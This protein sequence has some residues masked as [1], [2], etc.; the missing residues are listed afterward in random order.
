MTLQSGRFSQI[1]SHIRKTFQ[2]SASQINLVAAKNNFSSARAWTRVTQEWY[3]LSRFWLHHCIE[4]IACYNVVPISRYLIRAKWL[5]FSDT[6]TYTE[7][8][9][10]WS[11]KYGGLLTF[12][13]IIMWPCLGKTLVIISD[14]EILVARCSKHFAVHDVAVWFTI[15][16]TVPML[17]EL[18]YDHPINYFSRRQGKPVTWP[19]KGEICNVFRILY[20]FT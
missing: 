1:W 3:M 16:Y 20:L 14:F 17:C 6:V 13:P 2:N 12:T 8:M 18:K 15:A 11:H 4:W 9:S 5:V 19:V 10:H 7:K